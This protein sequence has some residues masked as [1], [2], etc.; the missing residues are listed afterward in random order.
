MQTPVK[1]LLT[2]LTTICV[3]AC[4]NVTHTATDSID[5]VYNFSDVTPTLSKPIFSN[6]K[7]GDFTIDPEFTTLKEVLGQLGGTIEHKGDAGE[8]VYWLCYTQKESADKS[9]TLWVMS[10]GEM[11]GPEHE[12]TAIAVTKNKNG[13]AV[14]GCDTPLPT[15]VE[16]RFTDIPSI[17]ADMNALKVHFGKVELD[18]GNK[19]TLLSEYAASPEGGV[20]VQT[21]SY[22]IEKD[23]VVAVSIRQIS[24]AD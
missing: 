10:D 24:T 19:F 4:D 13:K 21:I 11:G 7:I 14:K 1:I 12:I 8:S 17:A 2:T 3:C 23:Q 5:A 22:T 15:N 6:V 9:S 18:Q 20:T 16:V